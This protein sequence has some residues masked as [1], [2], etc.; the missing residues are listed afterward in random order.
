MMG[1]TL[2]FNLLWI[3]CGLSLFFYAA[4]AVAATFGTHP[5]DVGIENAA[6]IVSAA[7]AFE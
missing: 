3:C 5:L 7:K 4:H 6:K 1:K 2:R